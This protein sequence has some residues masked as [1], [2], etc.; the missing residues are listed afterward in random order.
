MTSIATVDVQQQFAQAMQALNHGDMLGAQS[1]LLDLND[2]EPGNDTILAALGSLALMAGQVDP[3]VAYLSQALSINGDNID[4]NLNLGLVAANSG[5]FDEALTLMGR[6]AELAPER[7]EVLF[8]LAN[9]QIQLN[10]HAK[11][12][13]LFEQIIQQEPAFI[14]AYGGLASLY[15]FAGQAE[16]A[17]S[18]LQA[19]LSVAPADLQL[20]LQLAEC[21]QYFSQPNKALE[22]YLGC[23]ERH[24]T[25]ALAYMALGKYQLQLGQQEAGLETLLQGLKLNPQDLEC[26]LLVADIFYDAGKYEQAEQYY[27][28]A[29]LLAPSNSRANEQIR[30]LNSLS[31]PQWHF[32]MLADTERNQAYQQVLEKHVSTNMQVLDI[33]TGSGLLAMMAARAGAEHV[34]A[35]EMHKKLAETARQIVAANGYADMISVINKKSTLMS[36][37]KEMGAQAD[38]VVSEILDVGGLGEGVIPSLRH[39]KENLAKPNAVLIPARVSLFAQVIEIPARS[40]VAP[41]RNLCG[42]DLSLLDSFRMPDEYISVNLQA[43]SYTAL[44]DVFPL[45][46]IDFY[47]LPPVYSHAQPNEIPLHVY[48][49][50]P[51]T[52]Q[53]VVFWFD[54]HLDDEVVL[55]SACGGELKHWGQALFCLPVTKPVQQGDRLELTLLQSDMGVSFRC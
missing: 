29:Q 43:E 42:F 33:G 35:C 23:V 4:A 11:A 26:L 17:I 3:A 15:A 44:S 9:L 46:D 21:F 5:E 10:N 34:Y 41:V 12:I 24:H 31:L 49:T 48:I 55:S 53:A 28:Q 13:V 32:Q 51:G 16:L 22:I 36:I 25:N 1:L 2:H 30:R 50:Q 8:N 39:A 6:A 7:S 37:G 38:L 52:A 18:T 14:A 40:I 47:N 45:L 20:A 54:L 27:Q 19:G